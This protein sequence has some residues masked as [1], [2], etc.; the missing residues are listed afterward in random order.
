MH[1]NGEIHLQSLGYMFTAFRSIVLMKQ[2]ILTEY[3][4]KTLGHVVP[5]LGVF[6]DTEGGSRTEETF[7]LKQELNRLTANL[8]PY[9]DGFPVKQY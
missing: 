8:I 3:Q 5:K 1:I 6:G 4:C 7:A 2:P 9:L